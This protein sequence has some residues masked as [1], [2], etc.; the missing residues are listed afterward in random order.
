M[1]VLDMV[2]DGEG[3][4]QQD[5][6]G[7]QRIDKIWEERSVQVKEDENGIVRFMAEIRF[8]RRLLQIKHSRADAGE[9]SCAGACRKLCE[10]RLITI[11][12]INLV[13]QRG[14]EQRMTPAAGGHIENLPF[15]KAMKLLDEKLGRWRI[16]AENLL[17]E[18]C[19]LNADS[20]GTGYGGDRGMQLPQP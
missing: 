6:A 20:N 7:C 3:F 10:G 19:A 14:E 9:I 8:M 11:D 5:T 17:R 1:P 18:P 2:I 13:A 4:I 12:G 15:G 16:C